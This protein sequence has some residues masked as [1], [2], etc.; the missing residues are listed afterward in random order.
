MRKIIITES[1][2]K[3]LINMVVTEQSTPNVPKEVVK[4]TKKTS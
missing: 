4:K 2:A 1:Q 3:K